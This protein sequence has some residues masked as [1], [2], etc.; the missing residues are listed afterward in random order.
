[1]TRLTSHVLV[2]TAF[3]SVAVAV[4]GIALVATGAEAPS[5]DAGVLAMNLILAVSAPVVGAV[6]A[7]H[8]PAN[9]LA[10]VFT[11]AGFGASITLFSYAYARYALE[12]AP[13]AAPGGVASAWVS[14]WVWTTGVMPLATFG[15]LLFPDGRPTSPR[16]RVVGWV[17]AAGIVLLG[18]A[19][20][21]APGPLVDHPVAPN[22]LGVPGAGPALA[23]LGGV[24]FALFCIAF[25]G[26]VASIGMRWRRADPMQQR[27]LRWLL[28]AVS[29]LAA[30]LVLDT[31]ATSVMT[32]V[33]TAAALGLLPVAVG[34]AIVR[35]HLYDVDVLISRSLVYGALTAGV[36]LT[37]VAVVSFV[38][39]LIGM[40]SG[41]A[42][43]LVATGIVA[44]AFQPARERL[45][46]IVARWVYGAQAD[47]YDALA[48]LGRRLEAT[49]EP[50]AVLPAVVESVATTMR[51]PF[52]AVELADEDGLRL[53]AS[54]GTPT[55]DTTSLLLT[56]QG[57]TIGQMLLG[58]RPSG[59]TLTGTERRLLEDLVRQA[60]IA[61]HGVRLTMALQRSRERIVVAREEERRRLRRDLHDG[62]GPTL[63]ALALQLGVLRRLI[64][65]DP[66][67]A[68]E[69]ADKVKADAQAAIPALR[70]VVHELRPPAL[71]EL[72]LASALRQQALA[73]STPGPSGQSV[74]VSVEA[75][76]DLP[77]VSAAT[78]VAA[79]RIV[80]EAI[81]N[82]VRHAAARTCHVRISSDRALRIEVEDDGRGIPDHPDVGVG[83]RSMRERAAELGGQCSI[84]R[85]P[86]GGTIVR[87]A[88]P[89]ET[90]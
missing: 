40:R 75:P 20:A 14:S 88:L 85:S 65:A 83:L 24:G 52:V 87:A 34:I 55:A 60:G 25:A 86:D 50:D 64:S 53:V 37:Y 38:G 17:A 59:A 30:A 58:R 89:L 67:S 3:A 41:L 42:A 90:R 9:R 31:L 72:G 1:M 68:C 28:Y 16:W 46:R 81:A 44:V 15:V 27:Q 26:S 51:L 5:K 29:V 62:L 69:L 48:R 73:L 21:L 45:Q 22:P 23:L 13:G 43:P 78:E 19:Q 71:D 57:Q 36:A 74:T 49:I 84:E 11:A 63:A 7:R 66:Q 56:H 79:Y 47:P 12:V 82:V 18:M 39:G 4:A 77:K 61:V 35:E 33:L 8:H 76:N 2:G 80:T 32:S 10:W 70:R 54:H 6:I